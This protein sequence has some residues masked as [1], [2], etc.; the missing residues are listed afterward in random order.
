MF[1]SVLI[2]NFKN[3][4]LILSYPFFSVDNIHLIHSICSDLYNCL[5][6]FVFIHSHPF[7]PKIDSFSSKIYFKNSFFVLFRSHPC[8]KFFFCKIWLFL[9]FFEK[10]QEVEKLIVNRQ[11]RQMHDCIQIHIILMMNLL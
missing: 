11:I 1:R 4:S 7:R 8:I 9:V 6:G 2:L 3:H 10:K 5:T